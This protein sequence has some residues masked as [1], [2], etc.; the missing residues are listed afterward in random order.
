[1][2]ASS[3]PPSIARRKPFLHALTRDRRASSPL[4][5]TEELR[6]RNLLR[7]HGG[8]R[9]LSQASGEMRTWFGDLAPG[10][11]SNLQG[12]N[13]ERGEEEASTRAVNHYLSTE[14]REWSARSLRRANA[15]NFL[16]QEVFEARAR[17]S[18][19]K[20]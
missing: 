16:L 2:A 6:I 11:G 9:I 15:K 20:V 12:A 13:T 17:V 14:L 18:A 3:S 19:L 8:E 7:A 5:R 1:M 4:T 10:C